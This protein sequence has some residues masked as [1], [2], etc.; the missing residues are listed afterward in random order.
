MSIRDLNFVFSDISEVSELLPFLFGILFVPKKSTYNLLVWFFAISALI[1]AISLITAKLHVNNML[2]FHFLTVYEF[3]LV[4]IFYCRIIFNRGP[5]VYFIALI[6]V[7]NVANSVFNENVQ[8]FNSMAWTLNTLI[9]LCFGLKYLYKLYQEL[10]T[11]QLEQ[12]P[13]FIINA[14]FL[15]YFSGSLFTYIFGWKILSAEARGFFHNAW[16]I[17]S[18]SNIIKNVIISYGLW[19]ARPR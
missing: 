9:L 7:I 3:V 19:L 6:I 18:F 10:E 11:T 5:S 13:L 4:Y 15:I 8:Q 2:L 1:K 14:G 12:N 17:Q 16:V